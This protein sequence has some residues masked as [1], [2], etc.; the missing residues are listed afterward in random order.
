MPDLRLSLSP[1]AASPAAESG[2]P[3]P[4]QRLKRAAVVALAVLLWACP[5]LAQAP[6][7]PSHSQDR[8]RQIETDL[9]HARAEQADRQEESRRLQTEAAA[10]QDKLKETAQRAKALEEALAASERRLDAL[11]AEEQAVL[12]QLEHQRATLSRLLGAMQMLERQKPPALLVAPDKAVDAVRSAILLDAL[13]PKV[14]QT[15]QKL[16]A[17]LENLQSLRRSIIAEQAK[18]AADSQQL[19]QER[20]AIGN[21]LVQKFEQQDRIDDQM[22]RERARILAL[23]RE[24]A[25]LKGLIEGLGPLSDLSARRPTPKPSPGDPAL[26]ASLPPEPGTE[27]LASPAAKAPPL[28]ALRFSQAKGRLQWPVAGRI[29]REYG[30][31]DSLGQTSLGLT[32]ATRPQAQVITPFDGKIVYAGPFLDHAQLLLIEVGEGYHMLLSGMA[33]IYGQVGDRLLAGEPVGMMGESAT[34]AAVETAATET[35]ATGAEAAPQLYLEFRQN[36]DPINPMPWL[37]AGERKVSG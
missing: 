26:R 31:R 24:R 2:V 33:V 23:G 32:I 15:A 35:A 22:A 27:R 37:V 19:D 4:N 36:G 17:Q 6:A 29:V 9:D 21:L 34:G 3:A 16:T 1:A 30:A 20:A 8:L 14:R 12:E 18:I 5:G 28:S 25:S 10:L 13:V 11:M 7:S